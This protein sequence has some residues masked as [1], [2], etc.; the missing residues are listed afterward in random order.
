MEVFC[1]DVLVDGD[2]V[3]GGDVGVVEEWVLSEVGD[4]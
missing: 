1:C 4:L 3:D 2:G